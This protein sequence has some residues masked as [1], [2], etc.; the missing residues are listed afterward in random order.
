MGED[1][2]TFG[3]AAYAYYGQIYHGHTYYSHLSRQRRPVLTMA[4][5]HGYTYYYLSRQRRPLESTSTSSVRNRCRNAATPRPPW[6]GVGVGVGV[7]VGLGL[8]FRVGAGVG[9]EG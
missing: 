9:V 1:V 2:R 8:E 5:L 3:A 7:G 6:L 4:N